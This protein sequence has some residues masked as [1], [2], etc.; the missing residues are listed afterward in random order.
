ML[1]RA[2]LKCRYHPYHVKNRHCKKKSHCLSSLQ[3]VRTKT[4]LFPFQ[5]GC[6]EW[7]QSERKRTTCCLLE[8]QMGFGKSLIS[9]SHAAQFHWNALFLTT[10]NTVAHIQAEVKKHFYLNVDVRSVT[11]FTSGLP[12]FVVVG[13]YREMGLLK[14][15]NPLFSHRFRT[16]ILDEIHQ[17]HDNNGV[18]NTQQIHTD[19]VLGLTGTFS[20]M[21][22]LIFE[23][24]FARYCALS[25][26]NATQWLQLANVELQTIRCVLEMTSDEKKMY[27]EEGRTLAAKQ[28]KPILLLNHMRKFLS[29]LKTD[30]VAKLVTTLFR[31]ESNAK[32]LVCTEHTCNVLPLLLR[33]DS[34]IGKRFQ[35]S[36]T[37]KPNQRQSTLR[38][39]EAEQN[40]AVLIA[41]R[42]IVGIGIDLGFVDA[43]ILVEPTYHLWQS[44]QLFGRLR[45]IGQNAKYFNPQELYEFV[46]ADS[47]ESKLAESN[48]PSPFC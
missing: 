3:T 2:R 40:G 7:L 35:L 6:L 28:L 42:D 32:I 21:N 31:R 17:M 12:P 16:L 11:N 22:C 4:T 43:L 10:A 23:A 27:R 36:G 9:L 26:L 41:T 18:R 24:C 1:R 34:K 25:T 20:K 5:R 44:K 14:P 46:F 8:L 37:V 29:T 47:C 39:F 30:H 33:I 45:R 19:F 48:E 13:S 15:E 38:Q